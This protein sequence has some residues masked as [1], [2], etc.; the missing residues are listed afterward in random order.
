MRKILLITVFFV[1]S[2]FNA[3]LFADDSAKAEDKKT[4]ISFKEYVE[5]L[6]LTKNTSLHVKHFWAKSKGRTY[7]WTAKV[8]NVK[9]GRGKAEIQAANS[10]VPTLNGINLILVSYHIDK[11]AGLNIGQEIKFKGQV[12]N[13]KGRRGKPIIVYMNNVELLPL[14][15]K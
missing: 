8:V 1:I 9:G 10:G 3:V 5:N 11:A 7:T 12:Y 13:Y 4:P 6:M 14:I 15:K 2:L